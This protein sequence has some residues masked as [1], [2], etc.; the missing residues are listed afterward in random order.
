MFTMDPFHIFVYYWARY[1]ALQLA[2]KDCSVHHSMKNNTTHYPFF[3][4][5]TSLDYL[6]SLELFP[7][8]L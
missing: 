7:I 8:D 2:D 4:F 6:F 3:K 5:D 1:Y